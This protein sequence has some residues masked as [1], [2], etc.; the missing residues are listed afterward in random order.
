MAVMF[1]C[2]IFKVRAVSLLAVM[3]AIEVGVEIDA[4]NCHPTGRSYPTTGQQYR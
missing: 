4:E 1:Y 2:R 3:V